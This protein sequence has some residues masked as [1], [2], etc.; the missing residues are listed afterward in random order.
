[1]NFKKIAKPEH[2]EENKSFTVDNLKMVKVTF[3]FPVWKSSSYEDICN[4]FDDSCLSI[5]DNGVIEESDMSLAELLDWNNTHNKENDWYFYH[6]D[7]EVTVK[8]I[9]DETKVAI[10]NKCNPKAKPKAKPKK[11]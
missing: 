3:T 9:V 10:A 8:D 11:K 6:R 1:M 4:E 5:R 7:L 2:S